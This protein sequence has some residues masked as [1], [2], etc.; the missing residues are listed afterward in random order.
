[1]RREEESLLQRLAH[2]HGIASDG[3]HAPERTRFALEHVIRRSLYMYSME[4]S[5][6]YL[7]VQTIAC[8]LVAKKSRVP[9]ALVRLI[10]TLPQTT[11]F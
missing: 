8:L 7:S 3:A 10:G 2:G 1:M 4:V 6:C 5:V 11:L 9:E